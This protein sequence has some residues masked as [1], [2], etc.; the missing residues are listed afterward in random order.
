MTR[1]RRTLNEA[2]RWASLF[3]QQHKREPK[4]AEI[5]L[6]H[7]TGLARADFL[8]SLRDSLTCE[9]DE[10]FIKDIEAHAA[11]GVP[12]Q[13]LMGK[14][15]FYG[16]DFSVNRHVLIPRPETEE[17]VAGVLDYLSAFDVNRPITLVDVGTG[18]GIIAVTLKCEQP[19]AE[20]IAADISAEA[21]AVAEHNAKQHGSEIAFLQGDFLQPLID[22]QISVDVLVSNPP[23]IPYQDKETLSDTVKNYDPGLA[24]FADQEGLAAYDKILRQAGQVLNKPG[25]IAF[26]IGHQQ[27]DRVSRLIRSQFPASEIEVRKDINGKDRMVFVQ[28]K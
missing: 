24:L 17:L 3:L 27:G 2:L 28:A 25:L 14:E 16:R 11:T 1:R 23:Y 4:V 5:L 7:H 6:Q 12:I 26:E 13:H 15:S 18:S 19:A 20:V 21:L 10:Q 9:A 22:R 8:A